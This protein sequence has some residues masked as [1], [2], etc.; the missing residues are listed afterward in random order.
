[1]KTKDRSYERTCLKK[2]HVEVPYAKEFCVAVVAFMWLGGGGIYFQLI[3]KQLTKEIMG[4][5][6]NM[7]STDFNFPPFIQLFDIFFE[8]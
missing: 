2:V 3:S 7:K 5:L 6:Q 4:M 8:T 1:M